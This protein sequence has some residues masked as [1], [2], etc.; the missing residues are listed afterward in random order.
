[1]EPDLVRRLPVAPASEL[2]WEDL[3]VRLEIVPRVVRNTLEEVSGP[4]AAETLARM[5]ATEAAVGRWLEAIATGGAAPAAAPLDGQADAESLSR[6]FASL[7]ARTFA[8]VQRRGLEVWRWEAGLEDGAPVSAYQ[9][10]SALAA[11]DGAALAE[12]RRGRPC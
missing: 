6:R 4:A 8:M 10:L 11:H 5:V 3:L 9:L 12:L 1:M 2:E 7:R